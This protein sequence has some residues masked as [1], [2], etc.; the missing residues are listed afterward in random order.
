MKKN[1]DF[2]LFYEVETREL[3]N[4]TLLK[5]Y[6]ENEGFSV[7]ISDSYGP[8]YLES[9]KKY[10]PK[11]VVVPWLR[12]NENF[13]RYSRFKMKI[14]QIVNLQC[15]QVYNTRLK[16]NGVSSINGLCKYAK[17]ICWG[18]TSYTRLCCNVKKNNLLIAGALHLDFCRPEFSS[19]YLTKNQLSKEFNLKQNRKWNIFVSS[20]SYATFSKK[21]INEIEK[22]YCDMQDF[23]EISKK[24][25]I[26]ILQWTENFLSN[27][28][29]VEYIYRPHP[30]ESYDQQLRDMENKYSNF[31][32]IRKYSVKQWIRVCD[33]INNWFST[34]LT[35]IYFLEK[36]CNI[37]RPL[38]IPEDL[39]N[40]MM[41]N[42]QFI[43]TERDFIEKN[44]IDSRDREFPID[45]NIIKSYYY[46]DKNIPTYKIIG[47]YLIDF[48]NSGE[49]IDYNF[50]D[51]EIKKYK[52]NLRKSL[53]YSYIS[54]INKKLNLKMSKLIFNKNSELKR[55]LENI[56]NY[57][58][59]E[60]RLQERE[61]KIRN[62]ILNK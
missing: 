58:G 43:T 17:H 12:N 19:Y 49:K 5:I 51:I 37:I 59:F 60:K 15:E 34:S 26:K 62:C 53:F 31:Y 9:I 36:S 29:D 14:R 2:L 39:E 10:I 13:F 44:K 28:P 50:T 20:F 7:R 22:S 57:I 4:L 32:V 45:E 61:T 24:S 55:K 56:E 6:L 38:K 3:E 8:Q 27:N 40:E 30:V 48:L 52:K 25:R 47:D 16:K 42:A 54:L 21:R 18:Q 23:I 11:I 33:I 1:I 46:F 35:E 41:A